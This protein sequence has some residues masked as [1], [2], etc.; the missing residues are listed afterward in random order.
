MG[1][2]QTTRLE[3]T[4]RIESD[5]RALDGNVVSPKRLALR[6]LKG[7][8]PETVLLISRGVSPKRL[9]LREL[10]AEW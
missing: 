3:R 6:E 8:P 9:A 2:T 4:E 1:F 5:V 10:K 7:R